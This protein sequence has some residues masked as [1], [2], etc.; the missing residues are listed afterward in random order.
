MSRIKNQ[1]SFQKEGYKRLSCR[2]CGR[3]LGETH[4]G[5][6]KIREIICKECKNYQKLFP[7]RVGLRNNIKGVYWVEEDDSC[8]TATPYL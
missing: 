6:T 1:T 5:E 2:N 4:L 8:W 3:I 7:P